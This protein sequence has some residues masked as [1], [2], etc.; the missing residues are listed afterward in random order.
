MKKLKG[1]ISDVR[2]VGGI[3]FFDLFGDD[4][5]QVVLTKE[6]SE[7]YKLVK[8]LKPGSVVEVEGHYRENPKLIAKREFHV[9]RIVNIQ[10]PDDPEHLAYINLEEPEHRAY[11]IRTA[12]SRAIFR[13]KA[14]IAEL[15]RKF[16]IDNGF[17]E[18]F[19]PLIVA[20]ATEGGAN[21]FPL[22]Y[23]KQRAYLAQSAQFYKQASV[24]ALW[25]VFGLIPSFR[26]EK[27]RSKRHLSEFWEIEIEAAFYNRESLMTL[28]ENLIYYI[29]TNI[30]EFCSREFRTLQDLA[31]REIQYL[32]NGKFKI[33]DEKINQKINELQ[34]Q[35]RKPEIKIPFQRVTYREIIKI[36]N[37]HHFKVRDNMDIGQAEESFLSTL[38]TNPFYITDF[39]ATIRGFY[40]KRVSENTSESVD[41]IL[42]E[43]HGEVMSGGERVSSYNE[44]KNAIES[45]G[46]LPDKYK[47]YL[48]MFKYGMPPHAGCG[49]GFERFTKWVCGVQNITDV[50]MF[51]RN[52]DVIVP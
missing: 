46:L 19:T 35:G 40:Y 52:P 31:V 43:G 36:L 7:D 30:Y 44:L 16:L 18:I 2:D 10:A 39:P 48:D 37:E 6:E 29:A 5:V 45:R 17:T 27:S 20:T 23:Y 41:L 13:I 42:H 12:K 32:E 15:T 3:F 34:Q 24:P 8:S 50:V 21:L 26:A 1:I 38:F 25:K 28:V 47:W 22:F 9:S 51:P 11:A 33:K 49:I 14:K 4:W